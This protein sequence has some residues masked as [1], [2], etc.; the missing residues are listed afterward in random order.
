[1]STLL[2]FVFRYASTPHN[3]AC[4]DELTSEDSLPAI[5]EAN[6]DIVRDCATR[7][8]AVHHETT[9]DQ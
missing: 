3:S 9:D 4:P 6:T 1:M 2:P 5:V 7:L 8:T